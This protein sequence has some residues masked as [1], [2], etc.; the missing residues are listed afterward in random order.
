MVSSFDSASAM[1]CSSTTTLP[2]TAGETI[3]GVFALNPAPVFVVFITTAGAR[4]PA[5]VPS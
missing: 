3:G 5:I 1:G 2:G 4:T